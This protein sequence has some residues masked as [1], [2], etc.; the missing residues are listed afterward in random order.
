MPVSI[1][2]KQPVLDTRVYEVRFP[3]GRTKDLAANAIA[4][5]LYAQCNS[6]GNE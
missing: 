2:H 5:A 6:D 4:E 1:A 3:D